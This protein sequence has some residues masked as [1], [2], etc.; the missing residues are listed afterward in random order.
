MTHQT[1]VIRDAQ[2]S[3]TDAVREVLEN[4]YAEYE[5]LLSR[6]RWEAYK[7]NIANSLIDANVKAHLLAEAEGTLLGS[8]F[9]Y[10]SS[11]A[12]YGLP[13]LNIHAPI[14]RLLAVTRQARG[15]GIATALI[16][17]TIERS[18]TW[19]ADTLYLHT[20]DVMQSAVQLYERLGFER[21]DDKDIHKGDSVV[22][23]YRLSLVEADRTIGGKR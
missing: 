17:E 19:G 21:A 7:E 20:S 6:E 3:D 18:R 16:A 13:E 2:P 23:S 1:I 12:A 22:K 15:Q 9:L 8:V 5:Q 14:M 10:H 4:A 11:D